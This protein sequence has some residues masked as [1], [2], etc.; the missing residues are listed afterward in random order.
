MG[1]CALKCLTAMSRGFE[2]HT[3]RQ[4]KRN[5]CLPKVPFLFI[6]AA[7]LAY[8]RRAKCGVYH[9]GLVAPL[10]IITRQRASYLR[11]DDIQTFGL[12]IYRNKLRMIYTPTA[13]FGTK[14]RGKS[15]GETQ[16]TIRNY[17]WKRTEA[18]LKALLFSLASASRLV[19]G[20]AHATVAN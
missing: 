17:N 3:L 1:D 7:G 5:F 6:L 13:W 4:Q 2:S 12:M 15:D 11:L 16:L 18:R 9:Q 14:E 19:R 10:Y 8:H 20:Q